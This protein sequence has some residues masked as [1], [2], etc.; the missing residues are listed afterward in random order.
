MSSFGFRCVLGDIFGICLV[1][2]PL[3]STFARARFAR[4]RTFTSFFQDK[5]SKTPSVGESDRRSCEQK[6]QNLLLRYLSCKIEKSA[7]VPWSS[8]YIRRTQFSINPMNAS[9][10]FDPPPPVLPNFL[11]SSL[12]WSNSPPPP[13]KK[14]VM[15]V[16]R[17]QSLGT[18]SNW[19]PAVANTGQR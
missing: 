16:A 8:C 11:P 10:G 1:S 17:S 19:R 4:A 18:E 13:P 7:L 3:Q 2:F 6:I 12:G 9:R 5:T 14:K 15:T